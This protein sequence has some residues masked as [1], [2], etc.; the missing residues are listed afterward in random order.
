MYYLG[1]IMLYIL[2]SSF[3]AFFI[4]KSYWGFTV[5]TST[6][7]LVLFIIYTFFLFGNGYTGG[8]VSGESYTLPG[9]TGIS[10]SIAASGF[11]DPLILVTSIIFLASAAIAGREKFPSSF[12]GLMLFAEF[13]MLGLLL[14]RDFLF[15]Y[16]FWEIVLIPVYFMISQHGSDRTGKVA[17]KFF[18]Y[19]QVGSIFML[20]SIFSLYSYYFVH[21]GAISLDISTLISPSFFSL[22]TP[23]ERDFILFGFFLAFLVKMP[24]FPIHAWF[25]DSYEKSPYPVTIIL[26][27]ALS[28]MG[29][30]GFFGILFPLWSFLKGT[31]ADILIGLGIVS[32]V[33]FALSAMFQAN[34]KRMMSYASAAA[35]GFVTLA[36]G[37]G[38]NSIGSSIVTSSSNSA[39]LALTGGMY[40][41]I[42]HALIMVLVFA[43]LYI[44]FLKT[45]REHVYD[46]GGLHRQAPKVSSLMLIGLMASLGLPGLAGFVGEFS[47]VVGSYSNIGYLIFAVIF[48]MLITASYHVWTAQR[49]LYGPYNETLGNVSDV[50]TRE[51]TLFLL[52]AIIIVV[53]GLFPNLFFSLF[54]NYI[55]GFA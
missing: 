3:A 14:S 9:S 27:G 53:L 11:T 54:V 2:L 21:Y 26:T 41:M 42:A 20:L 34:I 23:F 12:Y 40:Q 29:G 51:F 7:I 35:M 28:M 1:I 18:V 17:L 37:S 13:G 24:S 36:F 39:V 45:G 8:F 50:T 16:I 31:P 55:G 32:L 19:T 30:Y 15:F 33:Y 6:V 48:G 43:S 44:I 4:K 22:L 52:L 47:I 10:F 5:I 46:L 49:A 38:I 25:P